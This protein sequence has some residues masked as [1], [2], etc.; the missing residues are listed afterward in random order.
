MGLL[1]PFTRR[2]GDALVRQEPFL[3]R[4]GANGPVRS[5]DLMVLI[6][7]NRQRIQRLFFDGAP[8]MVIE[9][10]S[11]GSADVDYGAKYLE[12]EAAGVREYWIIDPERQVVDAY[13]LSA[14]GRYE[15]GPHLEGSVQ[16]A[17]L[18]GFSVE[19]SWLWDE[20]P[21]GVA[22]RALGLI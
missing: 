2:M 10:V 12:Y 20:P 21:Y 16:S 9:I 1:S 8:D 4:L 11:P 7:E 13:V 15:G 6:G 14:G 22:E 3:A 17:V 18:A 5:P 19:L